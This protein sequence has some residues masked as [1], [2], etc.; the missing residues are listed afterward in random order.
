MPAPTLGGIA[1]S[2]VEDQHFVNHGPGFVASAYEVERQRLL[3]KRFPEGN[4]PALVR[5]YCYV[6]LPT[7]RI[8]QAGVTYEE[9]GP[10]NCRGLDYG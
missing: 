1:E 5:S 2:T 10:N 7:A 6:R 9:H 8:R 4:T 3:R